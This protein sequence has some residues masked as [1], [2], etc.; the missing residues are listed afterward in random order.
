V[1][2]LISF[3][4]PS[5][6][7]RPFRRAARNPSPTD[8]LQPSPAKGR[9]CRRRQRREGRVAGALTPRSS[10]TSSAACSRCGPRA[11]GSR[12][13]SLSRRSASSAPSPAP[14]SSASPTSSS[15]RRPSRS[16]VRTSPPSFSSPAGRGGRSGLFAPPVGE[17]YVSWETGVRVSM[18]HWSNCTINL[19]CSGFND[20]F[21][22]IWMCFMRPFYFPGF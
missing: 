6:P 9:G 22:G 17:A 8:S 1:S 16:A 13:S 4:G 7:L 10:T 15:S 3:L 21:A 20:F 14:S 19:G 5:T 2:A 11:Q 18:K 12:C